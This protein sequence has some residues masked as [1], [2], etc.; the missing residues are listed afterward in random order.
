MLDWNSLDSTGLV[1]HGAI[2]EFMQPYNVEY[3]E[4]QLGL[5]KLSTAFG[6]CYLYPWRSLVI[7]ILSRLEGTFAYMGIRCSHGL[8]F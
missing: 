6:R 2:L 5:R 7:E 8:D 4:C 1:M 3:I